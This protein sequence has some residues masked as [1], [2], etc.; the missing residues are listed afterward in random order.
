MKIMPSPAMV[1]FCTYCS[2]RSLISSGSLTGVR[3]KESGSYMFGGIKKSTAKLDLP[4]L[5]IVTTN[6][7]RGD[8]GFTLKAS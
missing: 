5:I 8:R 3:I 4:A 2:S 1:R 6:L 7:K